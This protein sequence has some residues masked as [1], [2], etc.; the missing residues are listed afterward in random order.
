[1]I[2]GLF[3]KHLYER[4]MRNSASA[5]RG[6]IIEIFKK[7]YKHPS[8]SEADKNTLMTQIVMLPLMFHAIRSQ[9][10]Q[11]KN[12]YRTLRKRYLSKYSV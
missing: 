7:Y 1:M 4:K 11:Y 10:F 2:S 6:F 8:I 5:G 9:V 12:V 3:S